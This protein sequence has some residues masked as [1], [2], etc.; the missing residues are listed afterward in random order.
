MSLG[1]FPHRESAE[2]DGAPDLEYSCRG[3][4]VE[5]RQDGASAGSVDR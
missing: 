1:P 3:K 4:H 5:P 2:L